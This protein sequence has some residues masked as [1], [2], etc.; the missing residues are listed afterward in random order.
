MFSILRF[1]CS[2]WISNFKSEILPKLT[3]QVNI[4]PLDIRF[5]YSVVPYPFKF[6]TADGSKK[7]EFL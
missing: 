2:F 3:F 6:S 5:V 7:W 4:Q 1:I